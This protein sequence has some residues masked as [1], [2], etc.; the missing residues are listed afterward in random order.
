MLSIS[1][2]SK[3]DGMRCSFQIGQNKSFVQKMCDTVLLLE[4]GI[5]MRLIS[6]LLEQIAAPVSSIKT[7]PPSL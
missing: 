3:F 4:R 5:W 2:C 7:N 1:R 6:S